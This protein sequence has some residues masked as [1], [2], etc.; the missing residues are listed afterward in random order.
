MSDVVQSSL[1][2]R[3]DSPSSFLVVKD[4]ALARIAFQVTGGKINPLSRELILL[5]LELEERF[6]T[7]PEELPAEAPPPA[8]RVMPTRW[9][10]TCAAASNQALPSA[11]RPSHLEGS[12]VVATSS[13]ASAC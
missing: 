10:Y 8:I 13:M 4:L 7:P 1:K 12:M 3:G 6:T 2:F 11:S 9:A 5:G